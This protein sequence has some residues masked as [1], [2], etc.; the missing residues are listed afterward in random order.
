MRLPVTAI[1]SD[2]HDGATMRM[3]S[4]RYHVSDAT[5]RRVLVTGGARIRRGGRRGQTTADI[6][7]VVLDYLSGLSLADVAARHGISPD[8]VSSWVRRCGHT[9]RP[10]VRRVIGPELEAAIMAAQW[11]EPG[12]VVARRLGVS[13]SV[14]YRRW[15]GKRGVR[16]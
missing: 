1:L 4:R 16:G 7:A 13:R 9:V 8:T 6:N 2:Y 5:I 10:C 3:I 12:Y 15:H 11:R 14:V